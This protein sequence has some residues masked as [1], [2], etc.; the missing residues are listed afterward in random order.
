MGG[1]GITLSAAERQTLV[2]LQ[3]S[4]VA[5][6]RTQKRLAT[7]LMV[8]RA[9]DD[10]VRYF[11][12]RALGDRASDLLT[13]KNGISSGISTIRTALTALE[14]IEELIV[15]MRGLALSAKSSESF[16]R[17][18]LADQFNELRDQLDTLAND[19]TYQGLNLIG[20]APGT[21]D[22]RLN[23]NGARSE[24]HLAIAGSATDVRSLGISEVAR[25]VLINEGNFNNGGDEQLAWDDWLA[26]A[27]SGDPSA[28]GRVE[29]IN[30][31]G[32]QSSI[33]KWAS[34]GAPQVTV[35]HLSFSVTD[36]NDANVGPLAD[37]LDSYFAGG[38]ISWDANSDGVADTVYASSAAGWNIQ[39]G[40]SSGV[41]SWGGAQYL[42]NINKSLDQLDSALSTVRATAARFA[43][44]IATLQVR[45][46][47]TGNLVTSLLEGRGKLVNADLSE[48][49]AAMVTLQTRAQLSMSALSFAARAEGAVVSLFA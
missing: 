42:Q 39:V 25:L 47:F 28:P 19:A 29:R 15:Q 6:D 34:G 21:L 1:G 3:H 45:S 37:A 4:R 22:V 30:G 26:M 35:D 23:E 11:S 31:L 46:D 44:N 2:A 5:V 7:G 27:R 9:E 14:S 13:V 33:G 41:D 43:T 10:P 48:E 17:Q 12:A 18:N 8:A 36:I 32:V 40:V 49:G 38:G 16:E 24:S 20:S